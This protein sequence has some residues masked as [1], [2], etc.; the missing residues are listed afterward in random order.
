MRSPSDW[1]SQWTTSMRAAR[2]GCASWERSFVSTVR[3]QVLSEFIDAWNAGKRPDVDDYVA[4]VPEAERAELADDLIGFLAFAPT[5]EY[6]DEA[7]AAIRAE[8]VV[9]ETLAAASERSGLLPALLA[10]LRERFGMTP[11]DVAGRLVDELGLAA[12]RKPKM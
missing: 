11:D 8:P 3:E 4:R 6:S 7:L 1:G 5:P 2:A 9:A 12:D 10:R